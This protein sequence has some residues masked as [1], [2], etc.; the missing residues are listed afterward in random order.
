M[1]ETSRGKNI[2]GIWKGNY[3]NVFS[4]VTNTSNKADVEEYISSEVDVES[5]NVCVS[6]IVKAIKYLPDNSLTSR[7]CMTP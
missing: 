4:S 2:A 6:E 7:L 1:G 3:S 5:I